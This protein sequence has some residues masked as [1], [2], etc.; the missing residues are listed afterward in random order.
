MR[1]SRLIVLLFAGFAL[2]ACCH[3]ADEG[4]KMSL[5]NLREA[6]YHVN[7]DVQSV[8]AFIAKG[9]GRFPDGVN[10]FEFLT[11]WKPLRLYRTGGVFQKGSVSIYCFYDDAGVEFGYADATLKADNSFEFSCR[12][13][14]PPEF[15]DGAV[16]E[17]WELDW[18]LYDPRGY[19]LYGGFVESFLDMRVAF[20]AAGERARNE[21]K[22]D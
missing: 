18:I 22:I 4:Q 1:S 13:T 3:T 20:F 9:G 10:K 5:E 19:R 8:Y 12:E 2:A 6:A 16:V 14:D 21:M 7:H 11:S 15:Q 17:Q